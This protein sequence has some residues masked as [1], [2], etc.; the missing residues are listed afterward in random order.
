MLVATTVF[1]TDERARA[2]VLF[3]SGQNV[4]SLQPHRRARRVAIDLGMVAMLVVVAF[5]AMTFVG[6]VCAFMLTRA[7]DGAAWPPPGQ[8][9][10][11][12]GETAVNTAALLAAGGLVYRAA[13]TWENPEA[14][15]GPLL[16]AAIVLGSFF[17]FFQGVVWWNLIDE[18]L[19]VTSSHHGK[20]FC[21]IVGMHAGHTLAALAFL[22]VVW[23]RLKPFRDDDA[24]PRGPLHAS[25]FSAA[26][27]SWYFA[28]GVWP[29]LYLC[30]YL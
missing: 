25:A 4:I 5:E 28:V 19:R 3:V 2:G 15:I 20:F 23:L 16:L 22:S 12:L 17:L 7:A 14:R 1:P 27:I 11:P 6:L 30:L 9:W 26:R 13:R 18:G 24:P 8:P 29:F 21:L 10:F